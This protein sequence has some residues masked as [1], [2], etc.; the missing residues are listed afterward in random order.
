MDGWIAR[1]FKNQMSAFGSFMDPLADK[2]LVST[3]FITLTAVNLLPGNF[4]E[5]YQT[6]A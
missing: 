5:Y 3:L 4:K 6:S 2:L 1:N